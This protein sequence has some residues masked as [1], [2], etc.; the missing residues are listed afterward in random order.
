MQIT[1]SFGK[2]DRIDEVTC[3]RVFSKLTSGTLQIRV[4]I[5][6]EFRGAYFLSFFINIAVGIAV[7]RGLVV[8]RLGVTLV[9]GFKVHALLHV[10]IHVS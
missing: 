1:V 10:S 7:E 4:G 9:A 3:S 5:A 2:F 6:R 8:S